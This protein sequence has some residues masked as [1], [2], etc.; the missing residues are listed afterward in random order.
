MRTCG[1]W[2]DMHRFSCGSAGGQ[3]SDVFPE[4][5]STSSSSPSV[6]QP[7]GLLR[8]GGVLL[9]LLLLLGMKHFFFH[10]EYSQTMYLAGVGRHPAADYGNDGND[11]KQER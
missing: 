4:A 1:Q 2:A 3:C 10:S 6:T 8:M 11:G 7:T 9:L 5:E